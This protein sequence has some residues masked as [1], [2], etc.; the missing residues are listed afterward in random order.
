MT[1]MFSNLQR[2]S[3]SLFSDM[4]FFSFPHPCS[5]STICDPIYSNKLL[6]TAFFSFADLCSCS[7]VCDPPT[8]TGNEMPAK[9]QASIVVITWLV[10]MPSL[11]P[12]KAHT[13]QAVSIFVAD[14]HRPLCL[15]LI[16]GNLA[17]NS[18]MASDKH[19]QILDR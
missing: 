17:V 1:Q 3:T 5:C 11:S 9:C 7:T 2:L 8:A 6:H 4:A 10:Q 16:Q 12:R 15:V 14:Q 13:S 19:L 18:A